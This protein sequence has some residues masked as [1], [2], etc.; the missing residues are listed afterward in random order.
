MREA[1]KS[2]V[3]ANE[4]VSGLTISESMRVN[5]ELKKMCG[6]PERYFTLDHYP[7]L[8]DAYLPI[9]LFG[10]NPAKESKRKSPW[11]D[12]SDNSSK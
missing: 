2:A 3:L 10:W 6:V 7:M 1:L 5:G 4:R 8:D 12:E 11:G 9:A